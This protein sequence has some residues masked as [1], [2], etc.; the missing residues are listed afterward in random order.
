MCV[1]KIESGYVGID[2]WTGLDVDWW[3]MT[4]S[5]MSIIEI[6]SQLQ[7]KHTRYPVSVLSPEKCGS[8]WLFALL[9]MSQISNYEHK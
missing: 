7:L 8:D 3:K 6:W 1:N 4:E 5:N 9:S 2:Y